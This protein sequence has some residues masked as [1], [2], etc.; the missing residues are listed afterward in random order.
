MPPQL[1]RIMA[2][3]V[4]VPAGL[5]GGPSTITRPLPSHFT[6]AQPTWVRRR[7]WVRIMRRRLDIP[8]LPFLE[9]DGAMY[10][11]GFDG[12]LIPYKEDTVNPVDQEEGQELSVMQSTPMSS[13]QD[14]VARARYL[15]GNQNQEL[16]VN[17]TS[18][19]AP[20]A[21]RAI[22]KLEQAVSELRQGLLRTY[23][24]CKWNISFIILSTG[25]EDADRKI[26]AEVLLNAYSRELDRRRLSAGA[27]GLLISDDGEFS[28][29]NTFAD[30]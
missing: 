13:A 25:D 4:I 30:S 7:R 22:A 8:P 2:N 23:T 29:C 18:L 15:V 20:E 14:Y 5:G 6:R 16:D 17:G 10:H 19:S 3:N 28:I 11:L 1:E 12:S 21:R 9:A 26:Q 27:R 24:L